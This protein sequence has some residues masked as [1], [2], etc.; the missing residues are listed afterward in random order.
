MKQTTDGKKYEKDEEDEDDEDIPLRFQNLQRRSSLELLLNEKH[1]KPGNELGSDEV[2][3]EGTKAY[4]YEDGIDESMQGNDSFL[5]IDGGIVE[6]SD[7]DEII[8]LDTSRNL[9]LQSTNDPNAESYTQSGEDEAHQTSDTILD[10]ESAQT[11][12]LYKQQDLSQQDDDRMENR[13]YTKSNSSDGDLIT[14][15]NSSNENESAVV[16]STSFRP[17][18][19]SVLK[20]RTSISDLLI[21]PHRLTEERDAE[22]KSVNVSERVDS[23]SAS[24]FPD[25]ASNDIVEKGIESQTESRMGS[26]TKVNGGINESSFPEG[27]VADEANRM[28]DRIVASDLLESDKPAEPLP[29]TVSVKYLSQQMVEVSVS[30]SLLRVSPPHRISTVCGVYLKESENDYSLYGQTEIV[31][32]SI[33]PEY[34]RTFI[35]PYHPTNSLKFIVY[36]TEQPTLSQEKTPQF[37]LLE[38]PMNILLQNPS[39]ITHRKI[40]TSKGGYNREGYISVQAKLVKTML[41]FQLK[42][43]DVIRLDLYSESDPYFVINR[44]IEAEDGSSSSKAIYFSEIFMNEANPLFSTTQISLTA[45]Y[46]EDDFAQDLSISLYDWD[47]EKPTL[48]GTTMFSPLDLLVNPNSRLMLSNDRI[49]GGE[50][51]QR[52]V[53]WIEFPQFEIYDLNDNLESTSSESEQKRSPRQLSLRKPIRE[54]KIIIQEPQETHKDL[55]DLIDRFKAMT[56]AFGARQAAQNLLEC[57]QLL[58]EISNYILPKESSRAFFRQHG[59]LVCLVKTIRC[60]DATLSKLALSLMGYISI[61]AES[62][63]GLIKLGIMATLVANLYKSHDE[64][65]K[66]LLIWNI[67]HLV[68][69]EPNN[70]LAFKDLGGLPPLIGMMSSPDTSVKALTCWAI[71]SIVYQAEANKEAFRILGGLNQLISVIAARSTK[72]QTEAIH[73]LINVCESNDENRKYASEIGAIPPLIDLL[74]SR[75]E[76]VQDLGAYAL[77]VLVYNN[78]HG[79]EQVRFFQGI[80]PILHLVAKSSTNTKLTALHALQNIIYQDGNERACFLTKLIISKL[81]Q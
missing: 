8:D 62:R 53:G 21:K 18:I 28:T 57:N 32:G 50:D 7:G 25:F 5:Q 31:R 74:S 54:K 75:E 59:G 70:K 11:Q 6:R 20:H 4:V 39:T 40:S 29:T 26:S 22:R 45:L 17:R 66:K 36:D 34:T 71:T 30:C 69:H 16:H 43:M 41:R 24:Q 67:A 78:Q 33:S 14:K 15:Q 10:P 48:L 58:K 77:A 12:P 51:E 68:R 80:K 79:R 65:I 44:H 63:A 73:A 72:T 35:I 60:S 81:G 47:V 55:A 23:P 56:S 46:G 64:D 2:N 27:T 76:K 3:D 37:G 61:D 49:S 42:A 1:K 13:S 38:V 19:P 9:D 52:I